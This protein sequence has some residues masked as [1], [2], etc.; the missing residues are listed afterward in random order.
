[1]ATDYYKLLGV[2]A[3]A[4]ADELKKA[5]RSLARDLHPDRNPDDPDAEAKFKEVAH[6]YETLSDPERRAQYDRFGPDGAAAGFGGVAGGVGDI[7]EAFFGQGSPFGGGGGQ[8]QAPSRKGSDLEALVE[9]AFEEAVL[10]STKDVSVRTAIPCD[11][12]EGV[13]AES[14]ADV[15]VCDQCAGRGVVQQVRQSILGQMMSS[16]G[17]TSCAGTGERIQKPCVTC[18]GD[19]RVITE[20]TYT[21]DIPA[22]VDSGT[23]LRLTGRGAAGLRG[24]GFGDLYVQIRVEPHA[25]L[26][27]DGHNLVDE[28]HIPMT[29]AAIGGHLKYETLE[30][31]E[32]MVVPAGTQTGRVFRLRGRGVPSVRGRG[33]GDLVV[34]IVVDVPSELDARQGQLLRELAALRDEDVAPEGKGWLSKIKSAFS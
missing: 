17:C 32:D 25:T 9:V 8:A 34:H 1:M 27:R 2:A 11:T 21:V 30:G 16:V 14:E 5:Y 12:C 7:F 15:I 24:G 18:A 22:G 20:K 26:R 31:T 6:A 19:G 10:G 28:F 4:S 3:T 33:R 13:G 23:T 29:I